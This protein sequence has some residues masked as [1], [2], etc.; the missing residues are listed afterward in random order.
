MNFISDNEYLPILI[1]GYK[2]P[3]LLANLLSV[4]DNLKIKY[5]LYI[6]IDGFKDE[7][8]KK[9]VVECQQICESSSLEPTTYFSKTNLGCS[10]GPINAINW[11]FKNEKFGV[12][13]EDDCVPDIS[14]FSY[15][16]ELLIRY[17]SDERVFHISG[18]QFD[19]LKN[20]KYSYV[21]SRESHNWGWATWLRAW[22]QYE[23]FN[24]EGDEDQTIWDFQWQTKI[25]EKGG[26][27]ILP[28]V[29]LVKNVGYG[30][31]ATHTTEKEDCYIRETHH[32]KLPLIHPVLNLAKLYVTKSI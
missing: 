15:C 9:D 8:A 10:R 12:I 2:R 26:V 5:K 31:E 32:L 1:I 24:L 14:F 7:I 17:K 25:L 3:I 19:T 27:T 20:I 22:E 16:K 6:F 21:F 30:P 4:I 11:F 28:K 18:N 13:L 23:Y 29:N